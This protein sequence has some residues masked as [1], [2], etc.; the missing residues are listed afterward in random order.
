[1]I[2]LRLI[3][4]LRLVVTAADLLIKRTI[5]FYLTPKSMKDKLAINT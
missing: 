1:M 4:N 5:F 2:L 3:T